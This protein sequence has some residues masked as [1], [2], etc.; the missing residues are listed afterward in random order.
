MRYGAPLQIET[1]RLD[2]NEW[3]VEGYA[4]TYD[5]D[6]GGDA[7]VP[8]AFQKSLSSGRSVRFL[9][10]H[11]PGQV[12]GSVL[13]L[14][15]DDRGLHGRFKI[16]QTALGKDV[17]TLL[18]D[19]AL[20]SFSIGYL[21]R[22]SEVDKKSGVR[23]LTEVELLEVSVVAMPMNPAAVVTAVKA[24][25]YSQMDLDEVL[26]VFSEH[27]T[28]ALAQAKAVAERRLSEGR[29]L[30]DRTLEALERLRAA[31]EEDAAELLRLTTTPPAEKEETPAAVRTVGLVDTHLRRARLR[32]LSRL[33]GVNP[34]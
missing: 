3:L 25:D 11:N 15:E 22:E 9:F 5:R 28:S 13:D 7:V 30:S 18:K 19:E 10:S 33:Y 16:S 8:G 14:K 12:L 34:E 26:R 24:E 29:R 31:S 1:K 2:G 23:R 6:L 20:D 21:P 27:R 32:E 4:S 17:H